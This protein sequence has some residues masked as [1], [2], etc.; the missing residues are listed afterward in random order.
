MHPDPIPELKEQAARA[1]VPLVEVWS[2]GDAAA[3]IG[4]E[5]ERIANCVAA[6]SID[7]RSS[8]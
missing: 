8:G 4:V 5:R 3:L 7:S 6:S 1:L 2:R